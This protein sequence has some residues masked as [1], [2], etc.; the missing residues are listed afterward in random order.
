MRHQLLLP[1]LL[2]APLACQPL[3][4]DAAKGSQTVING[5]GGNVGTH[6]DPPL[7]PGPGGGGG[8]VDAG[9]LGAP[10]APS[11]RPCEM[12]RADAYKIVKDNCSFCHQNAGALGGAFSFILD[13]PM[14]VNRPSPAGLSKSLLVPGDPDA[15][16]IYFRIDKD[17]MPP[18]ERVPR[19]S[20]QNDLPVLRDFITRCLATPP[21]TGWPLINQSNQDAGAAP[22]GPPGA[23]GGPCKA[24]NT[25]DNGACCVFGLCRGVGQ[26]C[27]MS[28]TGDL[29]PGV[30]MAGS[31]VD[32]GKRCGSLTE[33][34]CAPLGKCTAPHAACG[35][36]TGKCDPC[37]GVG[38]LCC[39]FGG[40]CNDA[41]LSCI[42]GGGGGNPA[43]CELC[44]APGQPCCGEGVA[45]DKKCDKGACVN[46]QGTG[47]GK[48]DV[49]P[50]GAPAAPDGG[51]DAGG[52]GRDAG[53][54]TGGGRDAG[55]S[56]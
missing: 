20:R 2:W 29:V 50:G 31:C 25:C 8:P 14:V 51:V 37:G 36:R 21:Y 34:C 1:V 43:S 48:G 5:A 46:I 33:A 41:H 17:Q 30:C 42:G 13:L 24:A 11:G 27:G 3:N 35:L 6:P 28:A 49:C 18:A 54:D 40:F 39:D 26:A 12:V 4:Y 22:L 45:A 47:P 32:A 55:R 44:G 19:P 9:G 10:A 38:Q 53:A 56:D 7:S 52:G 16:L 15:S 23:P